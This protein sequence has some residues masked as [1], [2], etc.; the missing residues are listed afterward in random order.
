[1][2]ESILGVLVDNQGKRIDFIIID[3]GKMS[4]CKINAKKLVKK[5]FKNNCCNVVLAHN[6]PS[7]NCKPSENDIIATN[8]LKAALEILKINLLDHLIL[9]EKDDAYFSFKDNGLL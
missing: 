5:A 7:G 9:V 3:T 6:H 2:Y 8:N 4:N 1:M